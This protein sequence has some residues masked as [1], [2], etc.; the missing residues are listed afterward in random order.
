MLRGATVAFMVLVGNPGSLDIYPQL[1]HAAWNGWTLTDVVFPTFLWIVGISITLSLGRRLEQGESRS[2]LLLHAA[3]RSVVLYLLGVVLYSIPRFDLSTVRLLGVL[4]RI[5]ICSFF[6]TCIYLSGGIRRQFAWIAGF[7]IIYWTILS[8]IPA[9]G[10]HAGDLSMEGNLAHYIDRIVL[11]RHNYAGTATWDPEGLLSTVPAIATT[12][13]GLVCGTMLKQLKPLNVRCQKLLLTGLALLVLGFLSSHWMPINK[14]LWT[15]SFCLLMA[16]IDFTVF[17]ILLWWIDGKQKRQ[18][19]QP[20]LAFGQNA[21]AVYFTSEAIGAL[22]WGLPTPGN[23][24]H[25]Q[26]FS[27]LFAPLAA[28]RNASL[29]FAMVWLILIYLFAEV[30]YRRRWFIKL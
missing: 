30:L 13:F 11:G 3:R 17:S 19:L 6:A 10:F 15:V 26:L 2:G 20:F 22:L 4:Q 25:Q 14:K 28:P 27:L 18:G 12:V 7:L 24:V 8:R 29:L 21:L 1:D 23:S 5:A 16:G 9:P